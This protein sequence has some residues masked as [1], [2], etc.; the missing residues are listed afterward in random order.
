M[1]QNGISGRYQH[2]TVIV[3]TGID[4]ELK[5]CVYNWYALLIDAI[6]YVSHTY[7]GL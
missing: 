7:A 3:T 4:N 5:K 2:V 1:E 6:K